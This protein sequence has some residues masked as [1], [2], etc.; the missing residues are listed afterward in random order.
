[1]EL[2]KAAGATINAQDED[3]EKLIP[4]LRPAESIHPE[5]TSSFKKSKR[6]RHEV[7]LTPQ[8]I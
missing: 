4:R 2:K 6:V 8:G 7:V 5:S 1:M 3:F